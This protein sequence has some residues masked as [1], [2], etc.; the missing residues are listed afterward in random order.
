MS[1]HWAALWQHVAA[2]ENVASGGRTGFQP[3]SFSYDNAAADIA[4]CDRGG[5]VG[6][7][8]ETITTCIN[9][10]IYAQQLI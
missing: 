3:K 8:G 1:S 5:V 2:P 10:Y 4:N 9:L 6:A 7:T